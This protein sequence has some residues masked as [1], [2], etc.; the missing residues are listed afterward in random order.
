MRRVASVA[1]AVRSQEGSNRE[2][3]IQLAPTKRAITS[4]F[5][6]VQQ[7]LT[8]HISLFLLPSLQRCDGVRRWCSIPREFYPGQGEHGAGASCI[9]RSEGRISRFNSAYFLSSFSLFFLPF[10]LPGWFGCATR[11]RHQHCRRW[12][13]VRGGVG[14]RQDARDRP[15]HNGRRGT[16]VALL[17]CCTSHSLPL[18]PLVGVSLYEARSAGTRCWILVSISFKLYGYAT[19]NPVKKSG[20][21]GEERVE[22][23]GR[24]KKHFF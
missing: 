8:F 18:P 12:N 19:R 3:E 7:L 4:T 24:K 20:L 21:R 17:C 10:S 6:L 22:R 5:K 15:A 9:A 11:A 23:R 14:R 16:W 13:S 1:C 2:R